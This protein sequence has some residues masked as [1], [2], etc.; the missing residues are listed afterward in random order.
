MTLM[1]ARLQQFTTLF[2]ILL[3]AGWGAYFAGRGELAWAWA[4][5]MFILSGYALFLAAEFAM[6]AM[7]RQSEPAP[8]PTLRQLLG[9]WWSEVLTAPQV[10]CWRQPFR[11]RAEPDFTPATA[12]RVRGAVLV[13][14]F[15]CNRAI[16]NPWMVSLRSAGIP[17][18][19]V[20]LEPI[21]GSIDNYVPVVEAAVRRLEAATGQS[22][23]LVAHSMGGLAARAWL[24]ASDNDDRIHRVITIGTP[25][26]GTWLARFGHTTNG[27]QMRMGSDWLQQLSRREPPRRY[28]K[29]TCCYSHCDNIVFPA[30]NAILPGASNLHMPGTAHVHMAFEPEVFTEVLRWLRPHRAE[31]NE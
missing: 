13:H 28:T 7:V 25:H 1:L 21:F 22:P 9:A 2:L 4:G 10:F 5:A 16:W 23:V 18:A 8:H 24:A 19:A 15:V 17:F 6:L 12:D 29:F 11:S 30:R 26:H 3:A 14:G 31:P 27:R 20:N